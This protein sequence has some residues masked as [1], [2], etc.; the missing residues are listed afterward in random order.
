VIRLGCSFDQIIEIV[1]EVEAN[2]IADIKW[3]FDRKELGALSQ[4]PVSALFAYE[5][6]ELPPGF[7]N[8][9]SSKLV[10]KVKIAFAFQ[11]F[12]SSF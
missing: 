8:L 5:I 3:Y 6:Q 9:R 4:N 12:K 7:E 10:A 11:Q 2:P 1:C